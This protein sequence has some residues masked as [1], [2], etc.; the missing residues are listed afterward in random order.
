MRL[1]HRCGSGRGALFFC[2]ALWCA[3]CAL[4]PAWA[5]EPAAAIDEL[6]V[7]NSRRE[8]LLY[9]QVRDAFT[10]QMA[11]AVQSGLPLVF[12]F[13]VRLERV[14]PRWPDEEIAA[15]AFDHV[16]TYDALKEEYTVLC[17][18]E[19]GDDEGRRR[20]FRR[21]DEA[22]EWMGRVSGLS[23]TSLDRLTEGQDY[24]VAVQARLGERTLPFGLHY[25]LPFFSQ[26]DFETP[27]RTVRFRY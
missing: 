25:L 5:G 6:V 14:R 20:V 16:L 9:F 21:F 24:V 22:K 7:T 12:S 13:T 4:S 11:E 3:C 18:E 15:L 10:P 26:W 17:E 2:L 27:W 23:V 1:L 19:G 8:L